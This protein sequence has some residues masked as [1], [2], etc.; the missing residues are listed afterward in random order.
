MQ[1]R[2]FLGAVGIAGSVGVAGCGTVRP[3]TTLAE[4]TIN[5]ES[6]GRGSISFTANGTEIAS[7]G[8]DG[9]VASGAIDVSTEI[10]HRKGPGWSRSRWGSGCRRRD[11]APPRMSPFSRR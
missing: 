9:A 3:E 11:R 10:W 8:V 4:P 7:L 2:A 6:D 5:T 1:R